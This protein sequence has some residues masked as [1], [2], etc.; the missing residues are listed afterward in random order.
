MSQYETMIGGGISEEGLIN[1]LSRLGVVD[2]K[3]L[4]EL[5]HNSIDANRQGIVPRIAIKQRQ[6][7]EITIDSEEGT[8]CKF[9]VS[10]PRT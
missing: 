9:C 7:G 5:L 6:N 8:G 2:Y 3:A 10:L 1:N 4:N